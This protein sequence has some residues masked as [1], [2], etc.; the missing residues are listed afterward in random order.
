Y[1]VGGNSEEDGFKAANL[2]IHQGF[3]HVS[4]ISGGIKAWFLEGLPV[5]YVEDSGWCSDGSCG[6]GSCGSGG[7]GSEDEDYSDGCGGGC[8][9]G[10]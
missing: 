2:L 9:C 3:E 1:V 7:C 8:S 10:H 5:Q 6:S 4:Y